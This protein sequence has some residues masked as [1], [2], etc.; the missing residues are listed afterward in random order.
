M[1]QWLAAEE[2]AKPLRSQLNANKDLGRDAF[3]QIKRADQLSHAILLLS[4]QDV[5]KTVDFKRSSFSGGDSQVVDEFI[6][7]TNVL[8]KQA[9]ELRWEIDFAS[10]QGDE[11]RAAVARD[12]LAKT[13]PVLAKYVATL[14]TVE[15]HLK[16][17]RFSDD[18]GLRKFI[19]IQLKELNSVEKQSLQLQVD[20]IF[21]DARGNRETVKDLDEKIQEIEKNIA[22]YLRFIDR[23]NQRDLEKKKALDRYV[24]FA[25]LATIGGALG[26]RGIH[27]YVKDQINKRRMDQLEKRVGCLK[28]FAS[29]PTG[30]GRKPVQ[31]T[32]SERTSPPPRTQVEDTRQYGMVP[33]NLQ[34]SRDQ[35]PYDHFL[36]SPDGVSFAFDKEQRLLFG[37]DNTFTLK[38]QSPV[39]P[40]QPLLA[41]P[42]GVPPPR[43]PFFFVQQLA[44]MKPAITGKAE[45]LPRGLKRGETADVIETD[46]NRLRIAL[47]EMGGAPTIEFT[48]PTLGK[49][50]LREKEFRK[51]MLASVGAIP[52]ETNLSPDLILP[53][54]SK[55]LRFTE[56]VAAVIDPLVGNW[57]PRQREGFGYRVERRDPESWIHAWNDRLVIRYNPNTKESHL[58]ISLPHGGDRIRVTTELL[59]QALAIPDDRVK[60]PINPDSLDD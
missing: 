7:E 9:S 31:R 49:V 16:Q 10:F 29:I 24:P 22:R 34:Y 46:D 45:M 17:A 25:L 47:D 52:P 39:P 41:R 11:K 59:S 23:D 51:L 5:P 55:P 12:A 48:H 4:A 56:R 26:G 43:D 37:V 18:K 57:G 54:R 35:S 15:N 8:S 30:S 19:D 50:T 58:E 38:P 40:P 44:A 6:R 32:W 14:E 27:R 33:S 60:A 21:Q 13:E 1:E 20:R 28:Y 3:D 53:R 2:I 36:T 42:A